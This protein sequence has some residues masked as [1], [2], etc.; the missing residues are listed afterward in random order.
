[1]MFL[2]INDDEVP[3]SRNDF[4]PIEIAII[5]SP[6][7]V[8]VAQTSLTFPD[9]GGT[10]GRGSDNL[11]ALDD[12]NKYMSTVHAKIACVAQQYFLTDVSTNGTF[13]N[14]S[15]EPIG[16]GNQVNFK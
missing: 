15:T 4:M 11:W 3:V 12:P 13:I 5:K 10:L 7:T 16:N 8:N 1:M 2:L 6:S 9:A 14:G